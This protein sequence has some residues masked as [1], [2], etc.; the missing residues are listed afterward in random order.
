MVLHPKNTPAGLRLTHI[1][2]RN[3]P[4][5]HP[6]PT[7]NPRGYAYFLLTTITTNDSHLSALASH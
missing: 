3:T 5:T 4:I 7:N 6:K 2:K 1:A